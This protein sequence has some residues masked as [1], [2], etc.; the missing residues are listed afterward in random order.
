MDRSVVPMK[1]SSSVPLSNLK[2]IAISF[3]SYK[4][5]KILKLGHVALSHAPFEP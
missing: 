3:K 2:Q 4:G 1:G 5:P